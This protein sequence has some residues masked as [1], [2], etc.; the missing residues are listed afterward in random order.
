MNHQRNRGV[1]HETAQDEK[2][3]AQSVFI[4]RHPKKY[5]MR[6][7]PLKV[8]KAISS[9]SAYL[10]AQRRNERLFSFLALF[11]WWGIITTPA[12]T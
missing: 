8:I 9:V 6:L 1:E 4:S 7:Q 3:S 10:D 12:I 5:W 11:L 2:E